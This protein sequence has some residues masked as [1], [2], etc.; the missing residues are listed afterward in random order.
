[1]IKI[2][3]RDQRPIYEQ[4]KEEFKELIFR[5]VMEKDEQMPSVREMSAHLAI[6]PN[7]I[8]RAY[9]ELEQEGYIYSVKGRGSFVAEAQAHD[10]TKRK[11]KLFQ[12]LT[13]C[14]DELRYLGA[15]DEEIISA[16]N[17]TRKGGGKHD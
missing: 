8:Q 16:L 17:H 6:N 11:E 4:V 3:Y 15:S 5:G 7:T 13:A 14:A 1:M 9:R 2:D 10:N 12:I